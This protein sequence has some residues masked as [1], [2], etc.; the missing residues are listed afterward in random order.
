M[1]NFLGPE[2]KA[3]GRAWLKEKKVPSQW[4]IFRMAG[5]GAM[6]Q[7]PFVAYSAAHASERE[8]LAKGVSGA[9]GLA[10]YPATA[11]AITWGLGGAAQALSF[12]I[13]PP[14]GTALRA[15]LAVTG[16]I[17]A[18]HPNKIIEDSV[19]Q[20]IRTFSKLDG[21][22][23]RLEMGFGM[24]KDTPTTKALRSTALLEMSSAMQ[25]SRSYLGRESL[26][27]HR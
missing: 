22:M 5:T 17:L 21:Q 6:M 14:Y 25:P 20:G 8:R 11:A 3:L 27:F 12:M 23:R 18:S 19:F 7:L 4:T 26:L 1:I 10:T 2:A 13:P 16:L 9:V 24:F 15:G